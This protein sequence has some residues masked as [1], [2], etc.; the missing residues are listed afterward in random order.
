MSDSLPE[1]TPKAKRKVARLDKEALFR[2][3]QYEPTPGQLEVHRSRASRRVLACGVRWG[4]STL[5]AHEAIAAALAPADRGI[6]WV[7]APTYDLARRVFDAIVAVVTKHLAHRI[8]ALRE[9]EH[10]LILRN[11]G[12]GISEI[13]AKSADSPVSLLGEGLDWVILDEASRLKAEI[14]SSYI[15]QRLID[16]KGWAL[17][18]STPRGKGWFYEAWRRGQ[19]GDSGYQSWN[20]PTWSNPLLDPSVIE[21]EQARLPDR[22]FQQEYAAQFIENAGSVFRYVREAATATYQ[23]P[24]EGKRYFAG[25]DLAKTE[26]FTVLV[27]MTRKYEVVYVDRFHRLDWGL[28]I[29]RVRATLRRYNYASVLVD[30][31]GKGEPVFEALCAKGCNAEP[32]S[33]TS[34]TKND[35]ITNLAML[36]E[37]RKVVLPRSDVMP[38]LIDELEEFEYSVTEAGA[39]RMS[40]PGNRHDDCVIALA[41]AAMNVKRDPG[42]SRI[43][44]CDTWQDVERAMYAAPND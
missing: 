29:E 2:L 27:V 44:F 23:E 16:K 4:K 8:V 19:G 21:A 26:D 3:L 28:Q 9:H 15:S 38:E 32:Y 39:M 18:I 34:R 20:A 13:R 12:G 42:P 1:V 22:V 41:L 10:R 14:W 43:I 33:F 6:G 7:V 11:M 31:T 30:S 40:A 24:I 25:L 37:Q 5:A 35:L 36:L 17:L